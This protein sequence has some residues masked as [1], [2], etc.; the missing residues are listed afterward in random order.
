M[1]G[2]LGYA[3]KRDRSADSDPAW[4]SMQHLRPIERRVLDMRQNGV[5][6]EEIAR[7]I[8][9]SPE[10]VEQIVAWT[11]IPRSRPPTRRSPSAIEQRVL[12]M[13]G[14]GESHEQVGERLRRSP[15]NVRQVEALAHYRLGLELLKA[16]RDRP[17]ATS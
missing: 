15:A 1:A 8:R 13:L 4:R 6:T 11:S 9:K 10:R 12:A 17:E 16:G 7:R 5:K 2:G 3:R 14:A